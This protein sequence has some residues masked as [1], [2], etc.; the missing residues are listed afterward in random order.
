MDVS[1]YILELGIPQETLLFILSLP[2]I[3]TLATISRYVIGLKGFRVFFPIV[4][5]YA[6][7]ALGVRY[8]LAISAIVILVSILSRALMKKT[9][10]QYSSKMVLMVTMVGFA[11]LLALSIA[12]YLG[13]DRVFVRPFFPVLLLITLGEEFIDVLLKQGARSAWTLYAETIGLSVAGYY[14]ITWDAYRQFII[15]WPIIIFVAVLIVIVI[16]RWTGLR[17]TEVYR[18]RKVALIEGEKETESKK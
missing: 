5:T 16:G 12:A 4:T 6:F 3:A 17:L 8:A 2:I 13:I 15:E 10:L 18:F 11:I 1:R 14:L 7:V 9:R